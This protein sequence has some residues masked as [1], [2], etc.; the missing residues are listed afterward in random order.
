MEVDAMRK[1]FV[2]AGAA[3]CVGVALLATSTPTAAK[4]VLARIEVRGDTLPSPLEITDP[5]ILARFSIWNGPGVSVNG[6]PVHLDPNRQEGMFIDWP[7]GQVNARPPGLDSYDITFH[8]SLVRQVDDSQPPRSYSRTHIVRYEI[9]RSNNSGYIYLPDFNDEI[10]RTN[11]LIYHGVEGNWFYS[12]R[13]WE[14]L[15]RPLI[16]ARTVDRGG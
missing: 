15:V 4:G 2:F 3:L 13:A 10:G 12:T 5:A 16:L 7:K 9:D 6:Q 14:E 11:T 8:I 1:P